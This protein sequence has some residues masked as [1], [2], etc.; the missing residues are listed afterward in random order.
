MHVSS[1]FNKLIYKQICDLWIETGIANPARQDSYEIISKTL[2]L[3][4]MLYTLWDNKLLIG[5][6]WLSNDG[7]RMHAHHMCIHPDYQ[8]KGLAKLLLTPALEYSQK[9]GLQPKLEVHESNPV[10]R[11]LYKKNGFIELPGYIVMI[12]RK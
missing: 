8:G 3:G 10:A 9:C 4:G 11:E 12:K 7:R 2:S 5:T 6:I 1:S